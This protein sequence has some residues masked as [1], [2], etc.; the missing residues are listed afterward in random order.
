MAYRQPSIIRAS[1]ALVAVAW[2]A[3]TCG[4]DGPTRPQPVPNRAPVAAGTIPA[5]EVSVG[6]PVTVNVSANFSDPDGDAL[7]YTAASSDAEVATASVSGSTVTVTGVTAGTVTV[8]V[9]AR[10]PGGLSAQQSFAVT[11][12]WPRPAANS[13]SYL[14]PIPG[15][16]KGPRRF[17]PSA[18]ARARLRCQ[19]PRALPGG[20][21]VGRCRTPAFLDVYWGRVAVVITSLQDPVTPISGCSC[22][23][24]CK[25]A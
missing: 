19:I 1:M 3:A 4:G 20:R 7:S 21:I 6:R 2:V 14:G 8:T 5:R 13:L 17:L 11:A 15:V 10:D 12:E 22:A 16:Q 9:T 24:S 25:P 18:T 23:G